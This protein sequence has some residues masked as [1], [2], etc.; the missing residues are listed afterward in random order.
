MPQILAEV[1][2]E[3]VLAVAGA[4]VGVVD[5]GLLGDGE[6]DHGREDVELLPR[7][8]LLAGRVA[9]HL[10]VD[11]LRCVLAHVHGAA[12]APDAGPLDDVAGRVVVLGVGHVAGLEFQAA[13]VLVSVGYSFFF[14]KKK[15]SGENVRG[16]DFD[17]AFIVQDGL[18]QVGRGGDALGDGVDDLAGD[19]A[20]TVG[21]RQ[22][23]VRGTILGVNGRRLEDAAAQDGLNAGLAKD[24][25]STVLEVIG[26]RLRRKELLPRVDKRDFQRRVNQLQLGC[27]FDSDGACFC[28]M[29]RLRQFFFFPLSR[30]KPKKKRASHR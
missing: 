9:Q 24:G 14:Y 2:L 17:V 23:E 19:H 11:V 4:L 30:F 21:Q 25:Q 22:L 6:A 10:Q 26:Q 5:D 28:R 1:A 12:A 29:T 15:K 8:R 16:L 13:G 20:R 27:H 3:Q 18:R 7:S